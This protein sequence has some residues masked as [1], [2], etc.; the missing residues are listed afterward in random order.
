LVF[1]EFLFEG[2]AVGVDRLGAL[3]A[4]SHEIASSTTTL[5]CLPFNGLISL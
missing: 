4:F 2:K 3:D 5:T 1:N